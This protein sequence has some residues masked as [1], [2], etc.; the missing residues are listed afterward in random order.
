MTMTIKS[1]GGNIHWNYFIA[2]ERDLELISRYIEFTETNF[3]TFSIELAHLIFAAASEVDVIAKLLCKQ[4]EPDKSPNKIYAYRKI[5]KK[6]FPEV[7]SAIIHIPRY[8][9]SFTPWV[10]WAEDI[11]PDWWVSYN[12][13]KHKRN[14]S[15]SEAT[16]Q[17]ALN[18]IGGLLIFT[19]Q[20]YTTEF[21]RGRQL[22]ELLPRPTLLQM[23]YT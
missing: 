17:N 18:A 23:E 6:H 13:V 21:S 14:E 15:F 22:A 12:N 16:L 5:I 4:V 11:N 9:I 10:N 1:T 3:A 20:Y 2:L 19:H 7:L 8:G